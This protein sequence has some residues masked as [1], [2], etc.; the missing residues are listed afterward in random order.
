MFYSWL[1][2]AMERA[3]VFPTDLAGLLVPLHEK[4][5]GGYRPI[6]S[7]PS[8]YR[9]YMKVRVSDFAV[10]EQANDRAYFAAGHCWVSHAKG[11]Y[12]YG[13]PY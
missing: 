2:V 11:N 4:R 12:D 13:P 3:G 10:W 1:V 9:I 8:V 6:G 5:Q 7:F